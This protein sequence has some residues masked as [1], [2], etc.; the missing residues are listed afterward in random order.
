MVKVVLHNGKHRLETYA[1]L[2]DGSERTILLHSA[3]Q[4]LHLKG[5]SEDLALRTIR[6]DVKTVSGKSVSFSISSSAHPQKQFR[7]HEAFTAAELG[8]SKHSPSKQY[9]VV[10]TS[11]AGHF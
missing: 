3:A 9:D 11:R 4:K 1:I 5:Q 7:I 8:L 10:T 2:D 6:Q